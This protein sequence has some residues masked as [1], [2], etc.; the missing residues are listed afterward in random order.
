MRSDLRYATLPELGRVQFGPM[1]ESE[2][3]LVLHSFVEGY[4]FA[5]GHGPK[6]ESTHR[7][8]YLVS[9]GKDA[10]R[11]LES[12]A[13]V[14]V[15]RDDECP[16]RAFGWVMFNEELDA[17]HWVSVKRDFRR[18]GLASLLLQAAF[19]R[20]ASWYTLKSK[21]NARAAALGMRYLASEGKRSA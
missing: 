10:D 18:M 21:H 5:L 3:A 8:A 1:L 7:N 17:V 14:I 9:F 19:P 16:A 2:R 11:L 13:D 6:S 20:G 4:V 15:A 12:G